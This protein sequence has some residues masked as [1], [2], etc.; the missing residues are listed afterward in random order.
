MIDTEASNQLY[1]R[2]H[3][4]HHRNGGE[5]HQQVDMLG[6]ELWPLRD[7]HERRRR[8]HAVANHS[9]FFAFYLCVGGLEDVAQARG[10]VI[11]AEL[12]EAPVPEL[13][14]MDA[15][16]RVFAAVSVAA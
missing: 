16:G 8:A 11:Y 5:R 3:R 6:E 1:G 7:P 10:L 2:L 14:A 15:E 13:V 12:F 4:V 9:D